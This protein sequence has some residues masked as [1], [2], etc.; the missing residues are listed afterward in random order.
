M[1][2]P[3]ILSRRSRTAPSVLAVRFRE[4]DEFQRY[5]AWIGELLMETG[6]DVEAAWRQVSTFSEH[7]DGEPEPTTAARREFDDAV[8]FAQRQNLRIHG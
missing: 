4:D 1:A 8:P 7:W 3:P 6:G 2:T 5:V